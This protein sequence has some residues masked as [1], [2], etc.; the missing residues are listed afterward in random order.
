VPRM[1]AEEIVVECLKKEGVQY[2]FGSPGDDELALLDQIYRD[3]NIK[4]FDTRHENTGPIAAIGYAQATGHLAVCTATEGPGIA[5]FFNGIMCAW[6]SSAPIIALVCKHSPGIAER[7]AI[8]SFDQSAVFQHI[9]K[10]V[11]DVD[12]IEHI[13][14]ALWRAFRVASAPPTGPV[15]VCINENLFQHPG[16][17]LDIDLPPREHYHPASLITYTDPDLADRAARMLVEAQLPILLVDDRARW[18]N[19]DT[20]VA[21][22][23]NLLAAPVFQT[24]PTFRPLIPESSPLA[25]GSLGTDIVPPAARL[26]DEADLLLAI[27]CTFDGGLTTGSS[28]HEIGWIPGR[29]PKRIIQID[30]DPHYIAKFYPVELGILGHSKG[31]LMQIIQAVKK[32]G[33][34]EL[35]GAKRMEKL[36]IV[37]EEWFRFVDKEAERVKDKIPI[38]PLT[39]VRAMGKVMGANDMIVVGGADTRAIFQSLGTFVAPV[40]RMIFQN[41]QEASL[42]QTI[43]KAMGMKLACPQKRVS[44]LCGDGDFWFC[45]PAELETLRRHHLPITIIIANNGVFGNM[46]ATQSKCYGS[47]YFGT[48]I[49]NPDFAYLAKAFDMHS[50]RA[51]NPTDLESVMARALDSG[52]PSLVDVH[53]DPLAIRMADRHKVG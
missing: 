22:L 48:L 41:G 45:N 21:E 16:L 14:D 43:G 8:K 36:R 24:W 52:R 53:I 27:D 49:D 5:N 17:T 15:M 44:A 42:G 28:H 39:L 3:G 4:L 50:E 25:F 10:W 2:L 29:F 35:G 23:A 51:D 13:P 20:E 11:I 37:R 33:V 12:R 9:T 46:Y 7:D 40:P 38:D 47:R 32:L 18:N 31:V 26:R 1:T 19:T 34:N 30:S 6:R